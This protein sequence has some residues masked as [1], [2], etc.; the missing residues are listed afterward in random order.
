MGKDWMLLE[1]QTFFLLESVHAVMTFLEIHCLPSQVCI[2]SASL[3]LNHLRT[4]SR[5]VWFR[6]SKWLEKLLEIIWYYNI[7]FLS[8][9]KTRS[10]GRLWGAELLSEESMCAKAGA[11]ASGLFCSLFHWLGSLRLSTTLPHSALCST[12]VT[13]LWQQTVH[14]GVWGPASPS[15]ISPELESRERQ[16]HT[17]LH[18]A[19][20][21]EIGK[22]GMKSLISSSGGRARSSVPL[23]C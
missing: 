1:S 11:E 22:G 3:S 9:S 21:S 6:N 10:L 12:R 8:L 2:L 23:L 20:M 18:L 5:I 7:L 14:Q 13:G 19:C 17:D 15:T 4:D 16:G